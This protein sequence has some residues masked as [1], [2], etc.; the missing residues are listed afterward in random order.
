MAF[1]AFCSLSST[2]LCP[3]ISLSMKSLSQSLPF[4]FVS[5]ILHL[6]DRVLLQIDTSLFV[7]SGVMLFF[8]ANESA[9]VEHRRVIGHH[10]RANAFTFALVA[11]VSRACLRRSRPCSPPW[12]TRGSAVSP[13]A[14]RG[15]FA[16]ALVLSVRARFAES[17][18]VATA[19]AAVVVSVVALSFG[20]QAT[21]SVAAESAIMH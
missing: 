21:S 1:C 18:P 6:V 11:F 9:L 2:F 4:A 20:L 19:P 3:S 13:T 12:R 16:A 5:K 14:V 8:F 10:L 7:E 15:C 17:D